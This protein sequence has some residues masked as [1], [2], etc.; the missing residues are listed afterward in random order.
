MALPKFLEAI[1]LMV[2]SQNVT[3]FEKG[4]APAHFVWLQNRW[5]VS[6]QS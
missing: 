6:K 5:L 4:F 2:K 1:I 3:V